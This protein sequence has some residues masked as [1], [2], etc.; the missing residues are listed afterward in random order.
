[1]PDW[2]LGGYAAP[3]ATPPPWRTALRTLPGH[4]APICVPTARMDR[5]VIVL[6]AFCVMALGPHVPAVAA[7]QVRRAPGSKRLIDV[8]RAARWAMSPGEGHAPLQGNHG[9]RRASAIHADFRKVSGRATLQVSSV[10]THG[11]DEGYRLR[12]RAPL[13]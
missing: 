7:A 4:S 9:A 6:L 1:M 5:R 2:L 11:A 8:T 12:A 10:E 13:A 3:L